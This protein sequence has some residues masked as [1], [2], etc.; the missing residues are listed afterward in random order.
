VL[1]LEV[2]GVLSDI[3]VGL[4]GLSPGSLIE[5]TVAV[6][7]GVAANA[8]VRWKRIS[9]PAAP[10][11]AASEI[12]LMMSVSPLGEGSTTFSGLEVK[13]VGGLG[14]DP[15]LLYEFNPATNGFEEATTG[16]AS[17]K[18]ALV[19]GNDFTATI[20][21][22]LAMQAIAGGLNVNL[23]AETGAMAGR[24]AGDYPAL[25]FWIGG[26]SAGRR[27][28]TLSKSGILRTLSVR[29]PVSLAGVSGGNDRF[30]FYSGGVLKGVLGG[31][32][33]GLQADVIEDI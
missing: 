3:T 6:K 25:E 11:D 28:A 18:A 26:G 13:W 15:A 27:M 19:G 10:E 29:E 31:I 12:E 5:R 8:E 30:R 4:V 20:A 9:G 23:L 33:V 17:G 22:S 14:F 2:D 32:G 7:L 16:I 1:G 21:G 24:S